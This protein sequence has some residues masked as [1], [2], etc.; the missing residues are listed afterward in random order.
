MTTYTKQIHNGTTGEITTIEMTETEFR[1]DRLGLPDSTPDADVNA[2]W[3]AYRAAQTAELSAEQ[4][5]IARVHDALVNLKSADW[6]TVQT[7]LNAVTDPAA[8]LLLTR[9]VQVVRLLVIETLQ[10][11]D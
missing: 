10:G 7:A 8:K 9:L 4:T 6:T 5:R 3:D 1:R 11:E 2:A